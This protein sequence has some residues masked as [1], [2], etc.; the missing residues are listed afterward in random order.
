M[1]E[2]GGSELK[3][4]IIGPLDVHTDRLSPRYLHGCE[5]PPPRQILNPGDI[6]SKKM[7]DAR[8]RVFDICENDIVSS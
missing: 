1:V 8:E 2:I 5:H 6:L 3:S 7:G 4:E